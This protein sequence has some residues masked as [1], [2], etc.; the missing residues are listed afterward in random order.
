MGLIALVNRV[1]N[2]P[3][4]FTTLMIAGFIMLGAG[5][6]LT[7]FISQWWL[8]R[9]SQKTIAGLRQGLVEKIFAVP[10][11]HFEETGAPRFMVALTEDVMEVGQ[12]LLGIPPT[13]V[14]TAI[15]LGGR[16]IL[17]CSPGRPPWECPAWSSSAPSS[18]ASSSRAASIISCRRAT[19]PK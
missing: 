12:A 17:V 19:K 15:L 2:R 1:L 14:T 11:R 5:K 6:V 4:A 10:I 18:T 3:H 16:C 13:A 9:F 7:S 8:A